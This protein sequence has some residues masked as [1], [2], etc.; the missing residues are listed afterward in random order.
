MAG[1]QLEI[2]RSL[3]LE[4]RSS[5]RGLFRRE[6]LERLFAEH[7]AR[8]RNHNERIWRLLNLELWFRAFLEGESHSIGTSR[9]DTN[10][11]KVNSKSQ[12]LA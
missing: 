10:W 2:V 6:A 4:P 11:V 1:P 9:A 7:C 3:L 8:H 5:A 12:V